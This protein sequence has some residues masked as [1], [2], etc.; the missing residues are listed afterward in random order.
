MSKVEKQPVP[1]ADLDENE[2]ARYLA[3]HPDFLRTH[4]DT[5]EIMDIPHDTGDAV[6]LI[7]HQVH[8]L[9]DTNHKLK[10]RF[11][12]LLNTAEANEKRV[13]QL[14]KLACL[15]AAATS[16]DA[17]AHALEKELHESLSVDG[18]F[19]AVDDKRTNGDTKKV[20]ILGESAAVDKI[21]IN[22]F[23]RGKPVCSTLKPNESETLF[24]IMDS[25]MASVAM[26]PLQLGDQRGII[27]LASRDPKHFT[28][29]MG[30][31]FLEQLSSLFSATLSRLF[32]QG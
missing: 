26:I 28:P 18:V 19:I 9:R 32:T 24:G 7:E 6:S 8:I 20:N 3:S 16:F 30:T 5:L 2:V 12:E 29:D 14:N 25:P 23:R 31:L 11:D 4:P 1:V 15:M 21:L 13:V 10:A 27:V 17:L 22:A